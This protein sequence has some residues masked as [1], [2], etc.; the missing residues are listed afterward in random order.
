[1]CGKIRI[2]RTCLSLWHGDVPDTADQERILLAPPVVWGHDHS[3]SGG[4]YVG[5]LFIRKP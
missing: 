5:F 3:V 1:M 4:H 2:L